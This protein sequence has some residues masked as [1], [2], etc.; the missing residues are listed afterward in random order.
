[1]SF[2]REEFRDFALERD[3]VGFYEDPITLSSGRESHWYVNWRDVVSDAHGLERTTDFILDLTDDL[4]LEPDCFYG[5][6]EGA[7]KLGVLTQYRWAAA[8]EDYGPGSHVVPMG[9]GESKDHGE[10]GDREFVG[11]PEGDV[12]ILEDVTT[13]GGSLLE[14]IRNLRRPGSEVVAAMV[15]T[16]RNERTDNG[17]TVREAVEGRGVD[18]HALSE[19]RELLPAAYR[20]QRPG[21]MIGRA[22]EESLRAQGTEV[23]LVEEGEVRNL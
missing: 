20:Q 3:V 16:D 23:S 12:V 17:D 22:I 10:E 14:E 18:Y 2:D 11:A 19:G 7:T 15:L 1:M 9:R 6:P 13:T 5:V 8:E 21:R 4:D